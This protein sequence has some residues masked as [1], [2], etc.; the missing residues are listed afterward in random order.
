MPRVLVVSISARAEQGHMLLP[1][2]L[3]SADCRTNALTPERYP[4][5][6]GQDGVST[7]PVEQ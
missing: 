2:L 6:G 4:E 1:E 5:K 3:G 7:C